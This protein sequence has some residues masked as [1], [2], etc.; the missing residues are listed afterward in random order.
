MRH[1][2]SLAGVRPAAGPV[3]VVAAN[4]GRRAHVRVEM[5]EHQGWSAPPFRSLQAG[6]R[7]PVSPEPGH[8]GARDSSASIARSGD[9]RNRHRS[10]YLAPVPPAMELR[11]IVG[12]HQPHEVQPGPAPHER[13]QRIDCVARAQIALDRGDSNRRA[14]R[15][16]PGRGEAGMER[17]H[18]LAVLERIAGRDKPPH[19]V[20]AERVAG[21]QR[22][23]PVSAM[24][25]VEAAAEQ[26]DAAATRA[27]HRGQGRN[28]PEPRTCHL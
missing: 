4:L 20:E 3:R 11:K 6:R 28:W 25:R 10:G 27:R 17:G 15:L 19:L 26:A 13:A 12:P 22:Y 5:Q 9:C 2:V 18:G 1:T 24:G 16:R 8:R 14:P 7:C 21:E 23:A